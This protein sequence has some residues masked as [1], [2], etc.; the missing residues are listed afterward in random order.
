MLRR[1]LFVIVAGLLS[2]NGAHAGLLA[3]QFTGTIEKMSYSSPD[4]TGDF[5]STD[6]VIVTF[7]V[8][9][10]VPG[11]SFSGWSASETYYRSIRSVSFSVGDYEHQYVPTSSGIYVANDDPISGGYRD[12][13]LFSTVEYPSTADPRA[14]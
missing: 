12:Q 11:E 3:Y 8:D 6:P 14:G 9:P 10:T 13:F 7:L 1:V 5:D 2:S 4:P